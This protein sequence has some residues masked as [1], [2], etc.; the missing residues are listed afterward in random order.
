MSLG[1]WPLVFCLQNYCFIFNK[2][3]RQIFPYFLRMGNLFGPIGFDIK[4]MGWSAESEFGQTITNINSNLTSSSSLVCSQHASVCFGSH[5]HIQVELPSWWPPRI[6]CLLQT[7]TLYH[8]RNLPFAFLL[9][10]FEL[11]VAMESLASMC[12]FHFL[13]LKVTRVLFVPQ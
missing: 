6:N 13:S 7:C 2:D 12:A 4:M 1:S 11:L 3:T 5:P 9:S 8:A 10:I